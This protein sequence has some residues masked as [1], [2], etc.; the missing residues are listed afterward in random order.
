[1]GMMRDL[2]ADLS[3]LRLLL[4]RLTDPLRR[5]DFSPEEWNA[6]I[7][8]WA[9]EL[10]GADSFPPEWSDIYAEYSRSV[11]QD[12][13]ALT[14]SRLAA[15]VSSRRGNGWQS[16]LLFL[17]GE[18][19]CPFLAARAAFLVATLAP[20]D[21]EQKFCGVDAVVRLLMDKESTPPAA[22]NGILAT[23]D[24]RLLPLLTPLHRLPTPRL[25]SLLLALEG[26]RLTPTS[27]SPSPKLSS[28]SLRPPHSWQTSFTPS[29]PG[30]SKIRLPNLCTP[31]RSPISSPASFPN[32]PGI[33]ATLK[34]S[35]SK[36]P[37]PGRQ[38]APEGSTFSSAIQV[39]SKFRS[40]FAALKLRRRS[41]IFHIVHRPG[42]YITKIMTT[43]CLHDDSS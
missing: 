17:R 37:I 31:G 15:F 29:P 33:S 32:S 22:L 40:A 11:A 7:S 26:S 30:A 38:A 43:S 20:S 41:G 18:S 23:A 8:A 25:S 16:L 27:P 6:A 24:R 14:L 5:A 12:S 21:T 9:L 34:S 2:E 35:D 13:R 36:K 1:M 4:S 28:A 42:L 39:V 3:G 10:A 19:S